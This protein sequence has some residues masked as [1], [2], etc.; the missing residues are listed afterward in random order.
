[1]KARDWLHQHTIRAHLLAPIWLRIPEKRR[2]TIVS[3]LDKSQR[4]CWS[5]LVGDALASPELD[6]CDVHVPALPPSRPP[7]CASVCYWSH[8][9]HVG[10]HDC[11]CYCGKFRFAATQGLTSRT[12]T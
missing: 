7:H 10:E 1:M 5:D 8:T 2:W 12:S 3:W 9:D 6:A 4:R 11:S